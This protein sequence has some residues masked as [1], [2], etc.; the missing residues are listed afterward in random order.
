MQTE[1]VV[2]V[3][4]W[5]RLM[6]LPI[7]F[8]S[9]KGAIFALSQMTQDVSNDLERNR[10]GRRV[11]SG[12]STE[13]QRNA[14][15]SPLGPPSQCGPEIPEGRPVRDQNQTIKSKFFSHLPQKKISVSYWSD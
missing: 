13:C 2:V 5:R 4:D 1:M 3:R 10:L 6:G 14:D 15:A 11:G 8:L 9:C 7:E 12:Q